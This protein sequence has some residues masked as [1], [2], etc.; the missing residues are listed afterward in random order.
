MKY[1]AVAI[2]VIGAVIYWQQVRS[3]SN[4][5]PGEPSG[6]STLSSSAKKEPQGQQTINHQQVIVVPNDL[7]DPR[8]KGD[9][10]LKNLLADDSV[11]QSLAKTQELFKDTPNGE[12]IAVWVS[13]GK[14]LDS[15]PGYGEVLNYALTKISENAAINFS[16]IEKVTKNLSPAED[17]ERGQL[18]NLVNMMNINKEEKIKFFGN[19][20][21]RHAS[22]DQDGKWSADSLNL[23]TALIMLKNSNAKKED[24]LPYMR[25]SLRLN[26]NQAL[27][28]KLLA[29]FSSY[30]PGTADELGEY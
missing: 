25:E 19:E 14:V 1:K 29:R 4:V 17:F 3:T 18:I 26:T 13:L 30:F 10:Y 22:F 8:Y 24:V 28:I 12:D 23:T 16:H 21:S 15:S 27:K 7:N 2:V 5:E 9:E 20:L 6:V 11:M